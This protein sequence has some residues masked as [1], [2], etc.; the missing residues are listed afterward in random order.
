MKMCSEHQ[1]SFEENTHVYIYIYIYIER[2]RERE[3]ERG[4]VGQNYWISGVCPSFKNS[5]H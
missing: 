4:G 1:S 5:K 2:E 3:R